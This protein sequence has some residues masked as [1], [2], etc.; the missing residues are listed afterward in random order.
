MNR[1]TLYK[2][3]KYTNQICYKFTKDDSIQFS[4]MGIS[5]VEGAG[6]R[7]AGSRIIDN[8]LLVRFIPFLGGYNPAGPYPNPFPN[9]A[10]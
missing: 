6:A 8:N 9:P 2:S 3:L 10:W 7:N 5:L 1:Q 4:L